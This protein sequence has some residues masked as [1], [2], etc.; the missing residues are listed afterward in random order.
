MYAIRFDAKVEKIIAKWKKSNPIL[1]KKLRNVLQDIMQHPRTG[2]GHPEPLVGGG[3]ITYSRHISAHDRIIYLI[4]D[5]EV[6]VLVIEL[7]GHY[8]DK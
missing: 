5:K 1:F 3:D 2:I 4:H 7:E 6:L 8:K